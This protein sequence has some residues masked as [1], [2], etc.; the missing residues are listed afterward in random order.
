LKFSQN[1]WIGPDKSAKW[2]AQSEKRKAQS[3]KR[4]RVLTP[5]L[6]V[7]EKF[8]LADTSEIIFL[9]LLI[10]NR[11]IIFLSFYIE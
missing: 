5:L 1:V 9:K 4:K 3:A 6:F 8:P 10:D 7:L 2:K 11:H